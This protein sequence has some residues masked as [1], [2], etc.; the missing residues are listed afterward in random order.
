MNDARPI[1]DADPST[2]WTK[3]WPYTSLRLPERALEIERRDSGET[4]L[5]NP[6]PLE[7]YPVQ[8][9]DDLRRQAARIPD[10][11][12]LAQRGADGDWV[13]L[14]Y[15]A[16]RDRADRVSQWLLDNGHN[17]DNPV[18]ILSD[19]SLNFAVL[20]LGAMQVGIPA[21]PV[22]PAYSLMSKDFAKVRHVCDSFTPSLIYVED[23]ALFKPALEAVK[24]TATVV[25][26]RNVEAIDGAVPFDDLLAGEAGEA[27]ER[28]YAAVTGD[29][30]GKILLTSGSTGLPKGV[31][32]TQRLMCSSLTQIGQ[33]WPFLHDEP[34]VICDWLPWNHTFA[35]NFNFNTILR[36]GGTYWLDEGKPVPGRF[37]ATLRNLREVK[38]NQYVNV[39]RAYDLLVPALE[40]DPA[41][42][43]H[44]LGDCLYLF[45]A[46]AGL[47]QALWD[48]IEALSIRVR[49][50]RIP[51][52]TSL[53]STETGP[54]AI[55]GYWP[56]DRS[57]TVGLPIPG[58]EAKLAP[59]GGKTEIRF[60][61]PNIAP[62]YYRN[63]EK[64]AEAFDDEGFY[65]IGDAVKWLDEA[66]PMQGLSFDGRV[67][68][69]F[70]LLTGTWVATGVLRLD[71]LSFVGPLVSDAAV[72][73]EDR[74]EVGLLGFANLEACKAAIGPGAE[75]PA[76]EIS[77]AEIVAHPAVHDALREKIAAYNRE[78]PGSSQ[79]IAR[80]L[81]MTAPPDIDA[82]EIT[83]KGYL[84]QRAI[85]NARAEL[86][87]RLYA[88]E[89]GDVVAV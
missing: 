66:D 42:A 63:P 13:H 59:A 84:N 58:L 43:E 56:C 74:D 14:T 22:S 79:R 82:G 30:I 87:E 28:A 15:A 78:H 26:T 53:G 55:K 17:G 8:V 65:R 51:M 49:G 12:F 38:I 31:V 46:G 9:S 72:T 47:P 5:R 83:D 76:S 34:P 33:V 19:N 2:G 62:G 1:P 77:P 69:N 48:R 29:S 21:M 86:V 81:L 3:D 57:G 71:A 27:V 88:G 25:A 52:M 45:Y 50:A 80:I 4:I 67:A 35:A 73:G 16:A 68:E 39:A 23:A 54:P 85:L 24:P 89:G 64:T 10:R 41:F 75:G 6:T 36:F 18:A 70:K 40:A 20:Q 44:V 11:T 60:R 32:N 37:E 7:P 61:G